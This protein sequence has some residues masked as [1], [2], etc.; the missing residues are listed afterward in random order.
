MLTPG[1]LALLRDEIGSN[2]DDTT[3][4]GWYDELGHW[5]PVAIRALKR[6]RADATAGG[7]E[8]TSFSLDGVLSVGLSKADLKA[9]DRQIAYLENRWAAQSATPDPT[10][11][12][13][14]IVRPDRYR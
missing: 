12:V 1:D 9:L 6:R 8:T 2:P 13:T 5:L 14:R 4:E 7:T 3:L 10:P 11:N